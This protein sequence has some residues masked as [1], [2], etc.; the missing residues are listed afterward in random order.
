MSTA[1]KQQY[2]GPMLTSP[3]D[4]TKE[5]DFTFLSALPSGVQFDQNPTGDAAAT[6]PT[7]EADGRMALSVGTNNNIDYLVI[8]AW[9]VTLSDFDQVIFEL[10]GAEFG[11][12]NSMI[13]TRMADRSTQVASGGATLH[14][15]GAAVVGTDH[16]YSIGGS[17]TS[18]RGDWDPVSQSYPFDSGWWY[19]RNNAIVESGSLLNGNAIYRTV[20][21]GMNLGA[22]VPLGLFACYTSGGARTYWLKGARLRLWYK[23]SY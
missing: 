19:S 17:V 1:L 15:N 6:A 12:T 16:Q 22:C 18:Y 10:L 5:I 3:P 11:S 13:G 21:S 2:G 7:W 14:R 20:T 4:I 23:S 8:P 9:E